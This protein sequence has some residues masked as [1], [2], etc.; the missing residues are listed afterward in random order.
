MLRA[1][2][3]TD[4]AG[5]DAAFQELLLRHLRMR[6]GSGVDHERLHVRDIRQQRE[7]FQMVDEDFSRLCAALDLES[8]DRRAALREILLIKLVVGVR[9]DR[10]VIDLLDVGVLLEEIHDLQRILHMALNAQG[11]RLDALQ[12]QER[13]ERRNGRAGVAKQR[14]ANERDE[15]RRAERLVKLHAVVAVVRLDQPREAARLRPVELAALDDHAAH[16][17]AVAADELRRRVDDDIRAVLKR[18]ELIRRRKRRV[19]DDGDLVPVRHR[20]DAGDVD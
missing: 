8:K 17:R 16:R 11:K 14:R 13:M 20:R 6:R 9:L 1:D 3:E 4:R 19:H 15:R 2:G 18:T 5:R 10:R 7:D 12:K